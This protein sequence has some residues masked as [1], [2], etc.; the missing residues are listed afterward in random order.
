VTDFLQQYPHGVILALDEMSLYFQATLTRVWAPIG[1]TP[2]VDVHPQRE[3]VHFYGALN[4]R[5]GREIALPTLE[6]TSEMTT[7]FVLLLLLLYPQPI[8]LLLDRAT[9]HF[10]ELTDLVDQTDRLHLLYFPPACPDLNPQEHVWA[11]ARD[12]ISHNHTYHQFQ[13]LIDDFETFLNETLFSTDF[14]DAFSPLGL[15]VF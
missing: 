14:M 4:L 8:L 12:A 6:T 3:Q 1:H 7:N 9:W 13:P 5:D 15:G 2:I 11:R 10:A